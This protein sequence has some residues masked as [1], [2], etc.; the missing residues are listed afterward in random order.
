MRDLERI[1]RETRERN[2][3]WAYRRRDQLAGE[4]RKRFEEAMGI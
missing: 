2:R 4:R 1:V 3:G